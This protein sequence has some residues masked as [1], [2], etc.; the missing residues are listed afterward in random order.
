MPSFILKRA[1]ASRPDGQSD[2]DYDVLADGKPVGR[3]LEANTSSPSELRWVWS[4]TSIWP[5]RKGVTNG[6]G[7]TREGA[8]AKFRAAW[9][10][11]PFLIYSQRGIEPCPTH[12]RSSQ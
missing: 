4:I 7:A 6:K 2:E 11:G 3:I 10:A 1:T 12:R 9:E 8:M 5:A